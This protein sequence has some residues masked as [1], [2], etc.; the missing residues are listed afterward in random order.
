MVTR[1]FVPNQNQLHTQV[2]DF[3]AYNCDVVCWPDSIT[4]SSNFLIKPLTIV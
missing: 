3:S 4:F 1:L 2:V